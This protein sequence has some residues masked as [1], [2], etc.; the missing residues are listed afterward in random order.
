MSDPTSEN[1]DY[2]ITVTSE[3][4]E[5]FKRL[6]LYLVHKLPQFSRS[7]IR[8][9]FEAEDI[10]SETVSLSLNKLPPAGTRIEIEVPPP[11]PSDLS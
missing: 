10:S 8:R 2:E 5:A 1:V 11:V 4:R 3:D 6:D 7:T 9:L